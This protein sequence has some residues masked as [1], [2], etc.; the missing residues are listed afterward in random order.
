MSV[1]QT[2]RLNLRELGL[3]DF[4]AFILELLNEAGFLRF[5]G[6]KGVRTLADAREYMLKGPMDSYVRNGFGLYAACLQDGIPVGI[7]GLVKARR[8][9]RPG[10]GFC[11]SRAAPLER[12]CGRISRCRTGSRQAGS[13]A[14]SHCGN[15][16][17]RQ[18]IVDRSP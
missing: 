5:I 7:C 14:R 10:R 4:D 6:D 13:E 17:A 3:G 18:C 12:I 9:A 8:L 11:I 2:P 16:L 15:H 1:I